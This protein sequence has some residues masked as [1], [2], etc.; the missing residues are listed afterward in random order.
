[1]NRVAVVVSTGLLL[2]VAGLVAWFGAHRSSS[3]VPAQHASPPPP[4]QLRFGHNTPVDSALHAA[5]LRFAEEVGRKSSGRVTVEVFPAQ[6]L[7]NDH[8]MVELA[9]AGALD[10]LLTP[11]AKMSVPVPAMQY[12]DL[13]F[14][15]PSR[16]DVY[17]MLDGEPGRILLDK[18]REIGLVGVTFWEN[19]FKHFTAN[20]PIQQPE[21]FAGLKIRTMKSRIIMEQFRAVGAH[22]IP[23][24]FHATRQ[25]LAD[26]V[27][28]GEENPLVAIVSMGFHE[29]QPHLTLSSHAYLGYVFSISQKV[30]ERLP[31]DVRELLV[32]TARELTPWEREET[33]RREEALLEIIRA[34]G[35]TIHTLDEPARRRFAESMAHIPA[36]F[37]HL[38]G[39]DLLSKTEELLQSKY[40][41]G[42]ERPIIIGLD[43]DL[44]MD[45]RV[46]GLAI[47]RGAMLAIEEINARGGVLGRPLALQARDHRGMPSQGTSNIRAFG[48]QPDVVAILSGQHSPVVFAGLDLVHTLGLPL[49]A[50][51]SSASGVVENGRSPNFV[52]RISANDR[53]TGPY[54]VDHVLSR[55]RRPAILLENS[56]WGRGMLDSMERRLRERGSGFARVEVF[57]RAD[58]E[59]GPHLDRIG[60]SGADV[61][62]LIAKPNE[63]RH[64]LQAAARQADPLPV[65]SHWGIAGGDFWSANRELLRQVD[66]S[67]FQTFS[68][69]ASPDER[70]RKLA[71]AYCERFRTQSAR[72]ILAPAGVAHAYD[73]VHLLA[74]A[75]ER[76][77]APDRALVRSALEELQPFHGVVKY[78]DRPFTPERHDALGV[79]DYRMARFDAEGAV[80]PLATAGKSATTGRP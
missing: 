64:M 5:A 23:I 14:Y 71:R 33:H 32:E 61:I 27:V 57:N 12:A 60:Q 28:D 19:G 53:Q 25:A 31:Q 41:N 35:V 34:S 13:P 45:A 9:R 18:L 56:V 22:P 49:L 74:L 40:G 21:D 11:T 59:F 67:F 55:F 58:D 69:L 73:M 72:E 54:L 77:G 50:V 8:Q 30:F 76:A 16:Q 51:W 65:V 2:L 10:L 75:I 44:S 20:R 48:A 63:A 68:F 24:D 80:V 29:V 52:F 78:Y 36:M 42:A 43:A 66:L 46:S 79:E 47:K 4:L 7:G 17:D 1:M 70:G 37:E 15:F 26:G 38:I 6:L 62:V 3:P 39:A